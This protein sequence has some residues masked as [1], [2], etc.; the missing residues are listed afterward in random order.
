M[1]N[2]SKSVIDRY[3]PAFC[4]HAGRRNWTSR[5]FMQILWN[6]CLCNDFKA[7]G[8]YCVL[9]WM[10]AGIWDFAADIVFFLQK[11]SF[12]IW[13]IPFIPVFPVIAYQKPVRLLILFDIRESQL[14]FMKNIII[15][16]VVYTWNLPYQHVRTLSPAH[17]KQKS[18]PCRDALFF[19]M[20]VGDGF[21]PSKA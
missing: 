9:K 13:H 7:G 12:F 16:I 19:Q 2:G 6:L 1:L 21:E 5:S 10:F 15:M 11:F 17:L 14:W 4:H 8:W 20:V 3:S 18:H